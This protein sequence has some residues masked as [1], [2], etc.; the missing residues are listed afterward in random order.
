[1]R[2][3]NVVVPHES[4]S[5]LCQASLG[6]RQSIVV[7]TK[8]VRRA[9]RIVVVSPLKS[10]LLLSGKDPEDATAPPFWFV[11]GG[12]AEGDETAEAAARREL[13]EEVGAVVGDLGPVVWRRRV[14]FGF[15]GSWYEQDESFF[16]VL[17]E[18]F[19]PQATALTPLEQRTTT[20]ARWW[21]VQELLTTC[22]S[23]HP[24]GLGPLVANWL[25][26]GPPARPLWIS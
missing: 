9:G 13:Y 15:A 24:P 18:R 25:A 23:V 21:P 19:T 11:P 8:M 20:G 12:G 1:M 5:M 10:V 14:S 6:A 3:E 2:R 17:S 4:S 16:V 7:P 26:E 22:E